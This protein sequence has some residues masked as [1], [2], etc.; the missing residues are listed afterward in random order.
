MGGQP[1]L[2]A[3][4]NF[5]D[6][7]RS[8]VVM[9]SL[10]M[11]NIETSWEIR[12][13]RRYGWN[14]TVL[15]RLPR[16]VFYRARQ[17]F[18]SGKAKVPP[19]VIED[20]WR[21]FRKAEVR[22]YIVRMCAGYQGQLHRLPEAYGRISCPVF[23]LWG[24]T[25]K[26]FPVVQADALLDLLKDGRMQVIADGHHWMMLEQPEILA[27]AIEDFYSELH[28]IHPTHDLRIKRISHSTR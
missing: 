17:T 14:L 25:D 6:R 19:E 15:K 1:S 7:I 24:D 2:V 4:A 5:P 20:F 3:A 26:H 12:V 27:G 21:C 8:V 9:N 23:V 11:G 18:L 10:V 28:S 16:I 13:L 22:A